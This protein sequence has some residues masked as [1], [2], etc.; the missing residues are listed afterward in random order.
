MY[1]GS[2]IYTGFS[3]AH[4]L[5]QNFGGEHFARV[6]NFPPFPHARGTHTRTVDMTIARLRE[7]LDDEP[8]D[9]K[10]IKTVRGKGYMIVSDADEH[11][12]E[13]S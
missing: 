12:G 4:N 13:D 7:T 11:R 1:A 2:L 9:P 8:G 10:V 5:P 3:S 6:L